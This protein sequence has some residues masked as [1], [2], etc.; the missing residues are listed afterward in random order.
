MKKAL[1]VLVAGAA[2]LFA[3]SAYAVTITFSSEVVLTGTGKGNVLGVFSLKD[4]DPPGGDGL[5]SG[6]SGPSATDFSG[7]AFDRTNFF[8]QTAATL[9]ANDINGDFGIVFQVNEAGDKHLL[10]H[11]WNL[12]FYNSSGGLLFTGTYD[13]PPGGLDLAATGQGTSGYLFNVTFGPGEAALFFGD[14]GNTVGGQVLDSQAIS[15]VEDGSDNFFI[16]EAGGTPV[17]EPGSLVLL[18]SG[19]LGLGAWRRRRRNPSA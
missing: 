1:G 8:A 14:P 17:P 5:E 15:N 10:L 16:V 4:T 6:S 13:A 11:D 7:E 12:N 2:L 3:G 18:G 19:L 9:I